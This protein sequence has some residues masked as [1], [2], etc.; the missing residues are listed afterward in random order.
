MKTCFCNT[1][2][3]VFLWW[4]SWLYVV[5]VTRVFKWMQAFHWVSLLHA[6]SVH[7]SI[8][9][10]LL[11][12]SLF[13]LWVDP[14]TELTTVL[15]GKGL[16]QF[17]IIVKLFS[18][19]FGEFSPFSWNF[20]HPVFEKQIAIFTLKCPDKEMSSNGYHLKLNIVLKCE[21]VHVRNY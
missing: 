3:C 16:K 5:Y 7:M 15:V 4:T 6:L 9:L 11:M 8:L 12:R 18:Q 21:I 19:P 14:F 13:R 17:K 20:W 1:V 10:V 2:S